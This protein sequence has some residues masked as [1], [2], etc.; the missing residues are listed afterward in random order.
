MSPFCY[1]R[2]F[3]EAH[4]QIPEKPGWLW[5]V[6]SVERNQKEGRYRYCV[7]AGPGFDL[8]RGGQYARVL[9]DLYGIIVDVSVVRGEKRRICLPLPK[10]FNSTWEPLYGR[11]HLAYILPKRLF[12]LLTDQLI[13]DFTVTHIY[14]RTIRPKILPY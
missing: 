3:L 10:E 12:L 2:R 5:C 1:P 8:L 11:C 7:L 4:P 9:I 13:N 14:R 6:G